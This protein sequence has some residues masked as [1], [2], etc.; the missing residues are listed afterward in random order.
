M[1][2][3]ENH[4]GRGWFTRAQTAEIIGVSERQ[5]DG[6]YRK[7][8]P[9]SGVKNV[10]RLVYLN[11]PE[12]FKAI[13]ADARLAADPTSDDPL[14]SGPD[15]PALERFRTARAGLAERDLAERDK[16][17]VKGGLLSQ[18]LRAGINALRATGD[19]LIRKFGNEC[20]DIFN[21]GVNEFEAAAIRV[22]GPIDDSDIGKGAEGSEGQR[23]DS[24]PAVVGGDASAE[25]ANDL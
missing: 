9:S 18:A 8:L 22:L 17:L 25:T 15:S 12:L 5:I 21:E 23:D 16:E 14:M 19:R 2:E 3:S 13:V 11:L 24:N 20:G 6:K 7:M 10:G 1:P 4:P